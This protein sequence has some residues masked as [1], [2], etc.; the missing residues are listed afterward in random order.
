MKIAGKSMDFIYVSSFGTALNKNEIISDIFPK[1][2]FLVI[3]KVNGL[4]NIM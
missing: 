1:K 4:L 2:N 3:F